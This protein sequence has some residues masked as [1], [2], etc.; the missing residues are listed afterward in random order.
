MKVGVLGFQGGVYEQVYMVRRACEELNIE[1]KVEAVVEP[2]EILELDAL[3][4]PGGE[5][6]TILKVATRLGVWDYVRERVEGGL[7]IFGVC[8]GAI[9]M[10]KK[11]SDYH[12][13]KTLDGVLGV[14]NVEVTRNYY[15]RQRES[16]EVDV[17]IPELGE[18]PFRCIFIRAPAIT[19]VKPPA[20]KLATY[21]DVTIAA[22]ED[23]KLAVTFHP[24]LSGDTR[25]HKYFLKLVRR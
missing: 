15:G 7:P 1:C 19:N 4:L 2:R 10:A 6:T 3:I 18:E 23:S 17:R 14:M 20:K 11:V 9:L 22:I 13:G 16:F 25:F 21:E 5:S 12:T 8:A 24:E